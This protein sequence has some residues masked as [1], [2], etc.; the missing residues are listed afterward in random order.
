MTD[1]MNDPTPR[2]RE[3]IRLARREVDAAH[4]AEFAPI[5]RGPVVAALG[6]VALG[7]VAVPY[8]VWQRLTGRGQ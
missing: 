2:D 7:L 8:L 3:I 4:A 1:P 6:L 5:T